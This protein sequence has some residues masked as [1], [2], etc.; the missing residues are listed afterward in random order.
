MKAQNH[1]YIS[2]VLVFLTYILRWWVICG[3]S[4]YYLAISY[5]LFEEEKDQKRKTIKVK[6]SEKQHKKSDK[7]KIKIKHSEAKK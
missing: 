4:I 3:I 7:E 2:V 5:I 6:H 1:I